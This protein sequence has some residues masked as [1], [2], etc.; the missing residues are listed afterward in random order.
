[1]PDFPLVVE[2]LSFRYRDRQETAI[3]NI[4]FEAKP[5]EVLLIAGASGCG[6]TTLI[7]CINGLIPRSY[8]GDVNGRVLVFGEEVKDWKLSQISQKV[9]TVLQDP[10]RQI[11]GTKVLNEVAFGLENLNVPRGEILERVDEA[12][13]FLKIFHLR[14]RETFTLS[15]GEK[16]K[17]ALAGVLA[18]RPSILLLDEPLASLD[19][20]SA[21][22]ALDTA[23]FLADQGMTILMVEHRVEDVMRIQPERV[24]FMSEGE[25]RYLGEMSGLSKVVNYREVKLPAEQIIE[26]A[27]LDPPPAEI[28]ILPG[29]AGTGGALSRV[30]ASKEEP[31]VRFED[32]AFGYESSVE[33][34]HG[35]NLEIKRGDVIAV[36]GP[37]GAGKTTFVKHAIGLLK[38][39]SGR[40]LVNGQDT[41]ELS[42]AQIASTLGYVFQSPSHMLFAPTV[43]EELAFGPANLKHSKEQIEKEVKAALQIV[44]LADKE[45]DPPLALSFGQQKRVSIA[46]IL[47]MQSRILVMD[48]PTAGQDYQNY[49]NF[50]DSILQLPSFEAILFI[51]HDVDLAVIY[52]NRVLMIN[53]GRLVADGKPQDV[54]RDFD[55]L[56]ANRLVP[57]SLLALNLERFDTTGRFMRAEALAHI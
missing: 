14:E 39:K 40:V 30:E 8:K 54:L 36:L 52:S 28:Q 41:K 11:L 19:P 46:A 9:G 48:E 20:A 53:D 1:M 35:I 33:V 51:T 15:G 18:M 37:N 10:E 4:S 43:R 27:K 42:V 23:R 17:V 50:M 47:A 44:N 57:T 12:L 25:I 6:K 56:E 29:A 55:Q 16:Q 45:Q 38:P 3:R 32:V 31:L 21:R 2:N 49:M 34:L 7:R 13:R 24:M 26:R 5:G 22:D